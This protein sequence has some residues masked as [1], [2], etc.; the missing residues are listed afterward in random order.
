MI[1]IQGGGFLPEKHLLDRIGSIAKK[2][3]TVAYTVLALDCDYSI[4]KSTS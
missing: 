2:A 3:A 1:I 4:Q